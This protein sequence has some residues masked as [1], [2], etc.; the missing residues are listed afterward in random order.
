MRIPPCFCGQESRREGDVEKGMEI[1]PAAL[2]GGKLQGKEKPLGIAL[3]C[4]RPTLGSSR[5]ST[6]TSLRALLPPHPNPPAWVDSGLL[7]PAKTSHFPSHFLCAP[8]GPR[9]GTRDWAPRAPALPLLVPMDQARHLPPLPIPCFL[10]RGAH[11]PQGVHEL[12]M[13]PSIC[14]SARVASEA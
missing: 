4:G 3:H 1:H 7:L 5:G 12:E 8:R 10:S 11:L 13:L 6:K 2:E 9:V 14:R